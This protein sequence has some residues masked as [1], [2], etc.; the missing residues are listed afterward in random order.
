MFRLAVKDPVPFDAPLP[1]M[2]VPGGE[3]RNDVNDGGN[4]I[5]VQIKAA[6]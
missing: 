6:F 5:L 4:P 3:R 2:A 1:P